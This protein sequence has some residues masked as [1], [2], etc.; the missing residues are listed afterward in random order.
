[1]FQ[2]MRILASDLRTNSMPFE[3]GLLPT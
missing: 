1:V 3:L 2:T